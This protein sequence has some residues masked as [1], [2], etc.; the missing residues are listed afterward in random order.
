MNDWN[1]LCLHVGV[2]Y[3][4]IKNQPHWL[5]IEIPFELENVRI[6]LER[7]TAFAEPFVLVI[8]MVCS[9]THVG[10]LAALRYNA[11]IAVGALVV[12]NDRCYLRAALPLEDLSA[13][14][15]DRLIDFIARESIKL[16]R[17][18]SP[19]AEVSKILGMFEE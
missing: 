7:V 12:E 19:S 15:L 11:L 8:A 10:A 14:T 4:L 2:N 13:A 16:R 6:K 5:G 17:Q 1:D 3:Q 18:F 9:E